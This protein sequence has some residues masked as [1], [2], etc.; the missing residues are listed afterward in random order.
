MPSADELMLRIYPDM[1]LKERELISERTKAV[2]AA[3]KARGA[4]LGG[5]RGYRAAA[6]PESSAAALARRQMAEQA[7]HR[8]A[9]EVQARRE[10]GTATHQGV[11][12]LLYAA[13]LT[14]Q[15]TRLLVNADERR[16]GIGRILVKAAAQAAGTAGCS[17]LEILTPPDASSLEAFC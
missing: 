17:D 9:L 12:R 7:A 14:A 3:A 6:G 2:L 16:Q 5:D 1:A 15:V 13:R 4:V 10:A 11:A 8:L